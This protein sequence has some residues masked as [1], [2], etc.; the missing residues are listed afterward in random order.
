MCKPENC[1]KKIK[2]HVNNVSC[3]NECSLYGI[4]SSGGDSIEACS[5]ET[6]FIFHS[7][8]KLLIILL[9]LMCLWYKILQEVEK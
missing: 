2:K 3:I 5:I 6:E 8:N 4:L 1:A 9:F 7:G